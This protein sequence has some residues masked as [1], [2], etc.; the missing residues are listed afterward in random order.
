MI[1]AAL[2][3]ELRTLLRSPLRLVVLILTLGVGGFVIA[4]GQGDVQ[5]WREAIDAGRSKQEE[6]VA[7]ARAFL[8]ADQTGPEDRPWIDLTKPLWQDRYAATRLVRE[9]APLAGIAF[10]SLETDAVAVRISRSTDPLL[11][12]GAKIENPELEA[13]GGFD[14]VTVL[15]LFIPLLLLALGVE[16]GGHERA[17]GILPLIRVQSGGESRWLC[18]RCAVIGGIGAAAGLLLVLAASVAGA[19][20]LGSSLIFAGLV[21]CYVALWTSLLTVVALVARHPSQGAVALG[22]FW[23]VLCILVPALGVER[24]AAIGAED[25]ALDLTVDARDAGGAAGDLDDESVFESLLQRYPRLELDLPDERPS[26]SYVERGGLGFIELEERMKQRE[27]LG[28]EQVMLVER[29]SLASPVVA[30][31]RALE[32]LAGR[33]PG[34]AQEHQRAVLDAVSDRVERL[35]AG[36]WKGDPLDAGDFE[37]LLASTPEVLSS[38]QRAPTKD[39]VILIAWT[40]AFVAAAAL[41][42]RRGS[43][44]RQVPQSSVA[45]LA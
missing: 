24:A 45:A 13:A 43:R 20:D 34:A 35:I 37:E 41:L 10:A 12:Q 25:F 31:T 3:L 17:S 8:D 42:S 44:R 27:A 32:G 15:A 18:A 26:V 23:I 39:F 1:R 9:P 38:R 7:E 11:A 6:S 14:L 40:L 30:F 28:Q 21:L 16:V 2:G 4:Q 19:V 5:R 33:G 22:G 36:T 29:V